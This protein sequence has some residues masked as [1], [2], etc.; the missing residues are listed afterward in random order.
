[1]KRAFLR[2]LLDQRTSI[3]QRWRATLEQAPLHTPLAKPELL[4]YLMDQTL[5][6]LIL[7]AD[8]STSRD[9]G[10]GDLVTRMSP[11][12]CSTCALNPYIGFFLA[13]ES[14]LVSAVRSIEADPTLSEND[15]LSCETELL[16]AFRVMSHRE[17]NEF[18]EICW[19]THPAASSKERT[20][21]PRD[22]PFKASI[23]RFP[24]MTMADA[25]A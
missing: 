13:G 4:A 11:A 23:R 6:E 8:D 25:L 15:L 12:H 16:F 19:I 22:C 3:M 21:L 20:T 9:L 24:K 1:M 7:T 5:D 18:C 14:A 17:V 2:A 10:S